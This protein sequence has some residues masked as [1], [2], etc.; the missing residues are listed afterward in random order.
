MTKINFRILQFDDLESYRQIRLACLETYPDNFGTTFKEEL[1]VGTLKLDHIFSEN[2]SSD[3]IFGAFDNKQLIGICGFVKENRQ[4]TNHR[5]EI[6]QMY[7]NPIFSGQGT[8]TKLLRLAIDKAFE[9][10]IIERILLAVVY[11][12]DT[13]VKTYKKLGFVQYGILENYF[14]QGNNY[15]TQLFMVLTRIKY[16]MSQNIS[17]NKKGW[18]AKQKSTKP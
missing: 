5:G 2:S 12:N 15:W 16:S 14:K 1:N 4:K 13:A 7:V 9:S 10:G 6:V 18:P 8:G 3:F 17:T 11:S